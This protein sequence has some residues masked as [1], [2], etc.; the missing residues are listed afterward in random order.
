MMENKLFSDSSITE[1]MLMF[2]DNCSRYLLLPAI[3]KLS[4]IL[5]VDEDSLWKITALNPQVDISFVKLIKVED[6]TSF[7]EFLKTIE[8]KYNEIENRVNEIAKVLENYG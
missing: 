3:K 5:T 2:A 1:L 7:G 4:V 6:K 8:K